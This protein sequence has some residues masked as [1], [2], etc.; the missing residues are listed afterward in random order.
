MGLLSGAL[1]PAPIPA[2]I[3]LHTPLKDSKAELML[4]L[5]LVPRLALS[6]L[7]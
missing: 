4:G 5:T 2:E 3:S 7:N 6:K 1:A